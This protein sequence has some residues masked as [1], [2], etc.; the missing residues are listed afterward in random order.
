L[1]SNIQP[2]STTFQRQTGDCD[3]LSFLY[4]SLC[5]A[6]DIPARFI[7]GF[8]VEEENA[9][10]HAWVEV[11]VGE[12]I[13]ID[14]WIPVE[15]A[16]TA[17]NVEAEV[18][19]N[20]GVEDAGHVQLFKDDGSNESINMTLHPLS[21]VSYSPNIT[22]ASSYFVEIHNYIILELRELYIDKNGNRAYKN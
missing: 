1:D 6:V 11:F 13:G 9:V 19:Q 8:L 18:N 16:G 4:I 2:A 3:D 15:C 14:G 17:D 7:R 10:S 21:W 22:I 20:F 5:R 12:N